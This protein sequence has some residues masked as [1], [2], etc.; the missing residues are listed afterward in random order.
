[1]N[2]V[3]QVIAL[4]LVAVCVA[5]SLAHVGEFAGKMRLN[6]DAYRAVQTIYFPGFTVGGLSEPLAMLALAA[7][8]FFGDLGVRPFWMSAAAL[9]A[10]VAM[11]LVF[12]LITQPVNRV[13][14]KDLDLQG[15]GARF[16]GAKSS[17][18]PHA[19]GTADWKRLRDRW[20]YSHIARAALAGLAFVLLAIAV[21]TR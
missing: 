9:L 8:L 17:A 7:L 5:F 4:L 21:T 12:W 1:V 14:V 2:Q 6:E 20:E 13:W 18:P 3:L 10:L 11:Q 16:F 15:A 19:A